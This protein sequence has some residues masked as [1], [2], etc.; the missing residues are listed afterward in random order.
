MQFRPQPQQTETRRLASGRLSLAVLI[1]AL[2][3]FM[4]KVSLSLCPSQPTAS[5][6]DYGRN[7]EIGSNGNIRGLMGG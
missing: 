6:L 4:H 2:R 5:W 1:A 7:N 3:S